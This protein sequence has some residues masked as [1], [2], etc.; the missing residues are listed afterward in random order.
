MCSIYFKNELG[1]KAAAEI[2]IGDG[3]SLRELKELIHETDTYAEMSPQQKG[4]VFRGLA[5]FRFN[6]AATVGDMK[7]LEENP[8]DK[9]HY[10]D[11][12]L[13]AQA[14]IRGLLGIE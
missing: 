10:G 11:F 6:R 5:H 13:V 8:R 14:F 2:Q 9:V 3:T 7:Q 1:K 4:A 12:G